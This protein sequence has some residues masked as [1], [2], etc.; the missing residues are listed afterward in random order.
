MSDVFTDGLL[1]PAM[2][3][4]LV[5]WLMPKLLSMILPEGVW[6]LMLNAFLSSV[7]L[8]IL[9][10][11]FFAA[12]YVWQGVPLD[13]LL[14]PGWAANIVFFGRLGLIAGIIWGPIVILSVAGLP[15]TWKKAVW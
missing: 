3:L 15:R 6:P 8:Y 14:D 1:F 4:A 7:F 12:L 5:A 10:G 2:I 13:R 11:F 9:S